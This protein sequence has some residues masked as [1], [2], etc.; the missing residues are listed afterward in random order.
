MAPIET[1][2]RPSSEPLGPRSD[3]AGGMACSK[4][5]VTEQGRQDDNH[6]DA[7][8]NANNDERGPRLPF[9]HLNLR[10]RCLQSLT[11]EAMAL[12]LASH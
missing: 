1:G 9:I 8:C 3:V 7:N 5:A 12:A 11:L 4:G 2:W 6:A 10:K